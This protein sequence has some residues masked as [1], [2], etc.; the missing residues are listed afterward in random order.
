MRETLNW[1]TPKRGSTVLCGVR[2][3]KN[4]SPLGQNFLMELL[5]NGP[6]YKVTF[7]GLTI[8]VR[9]ETHPSSTMKP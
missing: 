3:N 1:G 7:S 2:G 8:K 6:L 9:D 4:A 5:F